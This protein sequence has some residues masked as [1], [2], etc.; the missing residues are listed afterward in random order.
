MA[1]GAQDPKNELGIKPGVLIDHASNGE[2]GWRQRD[3]PQ[4]SP[5]ALIPLIAEAVAESVQVLPEAF[6]NQFNQFRGVILRI[7]FV[8]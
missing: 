5:A 4:F 8:L 7:A 2:S 3:I 6:G 1:L